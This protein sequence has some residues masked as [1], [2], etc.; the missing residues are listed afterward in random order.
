MNTENSK[1]IIIGVVGHISPDKVT[2]FLN[3]L[4]ELPYF[5]LIRRETSDSKIWL[6]VE[7]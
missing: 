2:T 7:G 3:L 1:V 6:D 4:K 5:R